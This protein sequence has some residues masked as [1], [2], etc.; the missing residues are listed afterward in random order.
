LQ[1]EPTYSIIVKISNGAK[2][3][4]RENFKRSIGNIGP[5]DPGGGAKEPLGTPEI[6]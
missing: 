3:R 2:P 4:K 6:T 5:F 1:I